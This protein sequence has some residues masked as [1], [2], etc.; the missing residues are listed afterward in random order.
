MFP[1]QLSL[2]LNINT[3]EFSAFAFNP[4]A[5]SLPSREIKILIVTF[6]FTHFI[7]YI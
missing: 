4:D 6:L 1:R 3:T 5:T 2:C 7:F